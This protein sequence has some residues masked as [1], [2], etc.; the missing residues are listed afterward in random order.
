LRNGTYYVNWWITVDGTES[1]ST[2]ELSLIVNGKVASVSSTNQT[3]GQLIGNAIIVIPRGQTF[4]MVL[5]NTSG[6]DV[7]LADVKGQGGIVIL[8]IGVGCGSI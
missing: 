7:C 3:S 5:K 4:N 2:I 8:Q 6:D 1:K